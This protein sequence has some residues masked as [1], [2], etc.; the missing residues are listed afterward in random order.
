M[1]RARPTSE[2][3]P[4]SRPGSLRTSGRSPRGGLGGAGPAARAGP[5]GPGRPA[6]SVS[7]RRPSA[8]A[9][10]NLKSTAK[11]APSSPGRTCASQGGRPRSRGRSMSRPASVWKSA[12]GACSRTWWR[13]SKS[14]SRLRAPRPR[15][16]AGAGLPDVPDPH[17]QPGDGGRAGGEQV[18]RVGARGGRVRREDAER[19]Q[20][21]GVLG[22]LEVPER[23]VE[24]CEQISQQ[25]RACLASTTGEA[26]SQPPGGDYGQVRSS[27]AQ[28]TA[29]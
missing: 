23:Q 27:Y 21:H 9:W 7:A 25:S 22:G 24:G 29:D 2:T 20:V 17:A 1:S 4:R 11:E 16:R 26:S 8:R 5:W 3:A 13:G 18:G 28:L 12:V 14:G 15:R 10:W 19:A 6:A